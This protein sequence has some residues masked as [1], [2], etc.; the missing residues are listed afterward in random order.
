[1]YHIFT[2]LNFSE[3]FQQ[4][5]A[6]WVLTMSVDWEVKNRKEE[7]WLNYRQAYILLNSHLMRNGTHSVVGKSDLHC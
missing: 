5:R 4:K 2:L 1:M 6:K 3:R 7:K